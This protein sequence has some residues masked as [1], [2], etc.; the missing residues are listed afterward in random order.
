MFIT[1]RIS[2]REYLQAV[3][4]AALLVAVS[5]ARAEEKARESVY[6]PYA[7]LIGEWNV[8]ADGAK[9]AV[10]ARFRWGP[11]ESYMWYGVA[12]LQGDK[13]DPHFE[14]LLIWNG[15]RRNLDMLLALDLA[16]GR[17]QEQGTM[18]IEAD[19]TVVRDI[20]AYYTEGVRLPPRGEEVAGPEGATVHFR[21][22]FKAE[23]PDRVLTTL[24]RE[25]PDGWVPTFPGA[26]RMVMT[27]RT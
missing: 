13:E 14:G 26:D 27:R 23:S 7:F 10:V 20:T 9:P 24:M 3:A 16:G 19:G 1:Q 25:T 15:V 11:K 5:T 4:V 17:V 8:G 22:T 18:H 21:Q 12:T 6:A 2:F